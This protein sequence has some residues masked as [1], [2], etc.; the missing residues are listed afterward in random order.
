MSYRNVST[1]TYEFLTFRFSVNYACEIYLTALQVCFVVVFLARWRKLLTISPLYSETII[2]K[3]W[4]TIVVLWNVIHVHAVSLHFCLNMFSLD[5]AFKFPSSLVALLVEVHLGLH[6][7]FPAWPIDL[8][9]RCDFPF[10]AVVLWFSERE[11]YGSS[12][13]RKSRRSW[14]VIDIAVEARRR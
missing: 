2:C 9:A 13:I 7:E 3:G 12:T 6:C 11:R 10:D 5:L 8:R 4:E 14:D 1:R